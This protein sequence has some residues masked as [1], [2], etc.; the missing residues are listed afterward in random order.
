V[1]PPRTV[2]Q[3]RADAWA[4]F[5]KATTDGRTLTPDALAKAA[6]LTVG[7]AHR[8]LTD[9]HEQGR[10]MPLPTAPPPGLHKT[11]WTAP[12]VERRGGPSWSPAP[13]TGPM[14]SRTPPR[15]LGSTPSTAPGL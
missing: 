13:G 11:E 7:G 6:R 3:L 4:A 1:A 10:A 12:P 14:P 5:T 15:L 9:W 8:I 2:E